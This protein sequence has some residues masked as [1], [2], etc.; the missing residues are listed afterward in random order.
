MSA[1]PPTHTHTPHKHTHRPRIHPSTTF[2]PTP[3]HFLLAGTGGWDYNDDQPHPTVSCNDYSQADVDLA[4]SHSW[5]VTVSP[6]GINRCSSSL[7][8]SAAVAAAAAA[9]EENDP[10]PAAMMV[11]VA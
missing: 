9:E 10:P 1:P 4:N 7:Y 8:Q 11:Q 2:A 6:D 3:T 5:T